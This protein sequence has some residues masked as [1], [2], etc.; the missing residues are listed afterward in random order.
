V[1][2]NTHVAVVAVAWA[3]GIAAA[4][5]LI[6]A[7]LWAWPKYGAWKVEEDARAQLTAATLNKQIVVAQAQAKKDASAILAQ[8]EIERAKGVA[9]AT[10]ILSATLKGNDAYLH[11]LWI[12]ALQTGGN[13]V[14]YVP[15]EGQFPILDRNAAPPPAK[16]SFR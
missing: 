15:T 9:E 13:Q 3:A 5:L 6:V 14:I 16:P 1:N 2:N 8:A 10:R 11:Y 7:G 12:Q 4:I